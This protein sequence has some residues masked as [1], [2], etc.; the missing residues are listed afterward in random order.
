M[1]LSC[2]DAP[3][4]LS[5]S[6]ATSLVPLN[7]PGF[8]ALEPDSAA[9]RLWLHGGG[10]AARG[11]DEEGGFGDERPAARGRRPAV[12]RHGRGDA[13]SHRPDSARALRAGRCGED[14]RGRGR[15]LI[16]FCQ[17]LS[18]VIFMTAW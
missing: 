6:P 17:P 16:T 12:P 2:T 4:P 5:Y 1:W 11:G 9:D 10:R 14:P 15:R 7:C 13:G 3:S 8:G 18:G